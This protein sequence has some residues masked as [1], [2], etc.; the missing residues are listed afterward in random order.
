M[1]GN[2]AGVGGYCEADLLRVGGGCWLRRGVADW[3]NAAAGERVARRRKRASRDG[4]AVVCTG[5]Q[6]VGVRECGL[7]IEI[8]ELTR[9]VLIFIWA[10]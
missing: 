5:R 2:G 9:A 4:N 8:A 3:A 6:S 10:V 7:A 1:A